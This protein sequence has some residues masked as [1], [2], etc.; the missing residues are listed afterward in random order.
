MSVPPSENCIGTAKVGNSIA[1][2]PLSWCLR[3]LCFPEPQN[4]N[5]RLLDPSEFMIHKRPFSSLNS[6]GL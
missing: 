2:S 5:C 6:H 3:D 1:K 4:V